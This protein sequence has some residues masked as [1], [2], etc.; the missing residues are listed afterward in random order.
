MLANGAIRRVGENAFE[1]AQ[2]ELLHN[3]PQADRQRAAESVRA[4]SQWPTESEAYLAVA[5]EAD[6]VYEVALS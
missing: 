3:A 1:L 6:E 2:P 5:E 4:I